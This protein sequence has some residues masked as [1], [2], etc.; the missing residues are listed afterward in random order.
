MLDFS[1]KTM[2][3][4][5]Y[6]LHAYHRVRH[7]T[8]YQHSVGDPVWPSV[9]RWWSRTWLVPDHCLAQSNTGRHTIHSL[10]F[11][12]LRPMAPFSPGYVSGYSDIT[13]SSSLVSSP[14][15]ALVV[16]KCDVPLTVALTI[17]AI[18]AFI[19]VVLLS[20]ISSSNVSCNGTRR[21]I[22]LRGLLL[23]LL[24]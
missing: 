9:S 17:V 7:Y 11:C 1:S 20:D 13:H 3:T 2:N 8:H 14:P 10:A 24:G 5:R 18:A 19:V 12:P 4:Q 6:S 16:V 22:I 23:L 21:M 15:C